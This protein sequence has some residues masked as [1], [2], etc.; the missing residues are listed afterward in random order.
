MQDAAAPRLQLRDPGLVGVGDLAAI[1]NPAV[2]FQERLVLVAEAAQA[3]QQGCR[4]LFGSVAAI[5]RGRVG[6]RRGLLRGLFRNHAL[7]HVVLPF[8]RDHAFDDLL[9][10]V[11]QLRAPVGE[12]PDGHHLGAE[13]AGGHRGGA[14]DGRGFLLRGGM[15]AGGLLEPAA[16]IAALARE[17]ETGVFQLVFFQGQFGFGDLQ[18]AGGGIAG[19]R[20]LFE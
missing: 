17:V 9:A 7:Q 20:L 12:G 18:L 4:V 8:E 3:G 16:L 10:G 1:L 11:A 19:G 6:D 14:G 2:Q 13:R 5:A 15:F